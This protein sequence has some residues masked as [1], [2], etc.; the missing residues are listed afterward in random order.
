MVKSVNQEHF[1]ARPSYTPFV[2]SCRRISS[3]WGT[4]AATSKLKVR[5]EFSSLGPSSAQGS[6][7]K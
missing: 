6:L 7:I 4:V 3:R 5:P 2:V 1:R